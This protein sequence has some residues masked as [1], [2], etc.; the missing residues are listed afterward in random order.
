MTEDMIKESEVVT[1]EVVEEVVETTEEVT[2]EEATTETEFAKAEEDEEKKEEEPKEEEVVEEEEKP[3]DDEEE[4]KKKKEYSLEE[5]PEYVSL[6]ADYAALE[7][8][9][10]DL[11]SA[12]EALQAEL[13]PLKEFKN[14]ADLEAKKQMINSFCMLSEEDKKDV[15]D[16][17][18]T[19][20]LDEIEAKLSVICFRNKIN[21]SLEEEETEEEANLT[22]NLANSE[23]DSAPAWIKAVRKNVK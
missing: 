14:A 15:I 7:T 22:F 17:I 13:Q 9:Y 4:E 18:A 5:I 8:K 6:Q 11:A 3:E 19:Y 10:N 16:N 20:S 12:H 1:E 2:I 21:F 23:D